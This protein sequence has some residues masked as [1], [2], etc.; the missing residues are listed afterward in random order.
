ML[1]LKNGIRSI[2]QQL[3]LIKELKRGGIKR[4]KSK[5]YALRRY[6]KNGG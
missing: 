2:P 6:G 4:E 1:Y 5:A 3:F